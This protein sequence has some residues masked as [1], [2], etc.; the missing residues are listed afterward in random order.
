MSSFAEADAGIRQCYARFIDAVWRKDGEEYARQF[1][2]DGEWKIAGMHMKGREKIAEGCDFLLGRC[3]EIHL[4]VGHPIIEV[5]G[6]TAVARVNVTEITRMPDDLGYLTT[7]IYYDRFQ[8]EDGKWRFRWRHWNTKYRGPL[9][10]GGHFTGT[11]DYGAFPG[12]PEW[13]EETY[14]KP[15]TVK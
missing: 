5:D 13:D 14:V 15:A 9:E 6:D 11:S 3:K 10:L 1:T 12:M 2:S 8:V 4:I 7:G